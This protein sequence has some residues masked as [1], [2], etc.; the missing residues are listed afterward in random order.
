MAIS[1]EDVLKIAK[2]AHLRLAP[3]EAERY[4]S[5][6]VKILDSMEELSRLDT[7]AVEP[8]TS[9]LGLTDVMRDDVP[10]P[11]AAVEKLLANAPSRE[12]PYFRVKKVIE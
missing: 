7:S 10:E 6:L 2:L 5:Q 4:Q 12:G 1:K 11:F 3:E 8:T 9:V